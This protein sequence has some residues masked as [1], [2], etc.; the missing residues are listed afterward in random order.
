MAIKLKFDSQHNLIAP[1]FVLAHRNGKKIGAIKARNLNFSDNSNSAT[2]LSFVVDKFD[3]NVRYKYWDEVKDFRLVWCKEWD[4]WFEIRVQTDDENGTAKTI[5]GRTICEAEL[6]Q[7]YTGEMEINTDADIERDNYEPTIFFNES[8]PSSSLLHRILYKFPNYKILHVDDSIKNIQ[9][10]FSFS[11]NVSVYSALQTVSEEIDCIFVFDSGSDS[12]GKIIRGISVYDLESYCYDCNKRGVFTGTCPEC[13]STNIYEGYG[14]NTTIFI[15]TDNLADSITYSTDVDSVKNCFKLEAGDD[16]MTDTIINCNPNGT[17]YIWHISDDIKDDMDDELVEKINEYD[18]EYARYNSEYTTSFADI[19]DIA[20]DKSSARIPLDLKTNYN[21]LID[22]YKSAANE[23]DYTYTKLP[24]SVSGYPNLI[25]AYYNAIDFGLFLSNTMMPSSFIFAD[26]TAEIEAKKLTPTSLSP[27]SVQNIET[28]SNY[29]ASNSVL[30]MAKIIVDSRYQVKVLDSTLEDGS[31]DDTK[32]W[33]GNFKI[34]NYSDEEDSTTSAVITVEIN[35]NYDTFVRQKINKTLNSVDTGDATDIVSI[36]SLDINDGSFA[37]ELKKYCLNSLNS[38]HSAC[39]SCMDILI[40]QGIADNSNIYYSEMYAPY[41]Q[42][43]NIIEDEIALR[44]S[45]IAIIEGKYDSDGFIEKEGVKSAIEKVRRFV[46]NQLDFEYFLGSDLWYEFIAYRREEIYSNENYISDGLSNA[47]LLNNALEFIKVAQNEIYKSA[48]L[49]HSISATLKNLLVMKEF[50]KIVDYFEVGNWI[51]LKV[52]ENIYKLRLNNYQIDF[53]NM[54]NIQVEFSDV[55]K[56][57][58]GYSDIESTLAQAK[59]MSTTY[60]AVTRQAGQGEKSRKQLDNWV[61]DG[62]SLT[63]MKIINNAD[64]QNVVWD[65]HGMLCR[66]YSPITDEYDD[67]QTKIIN[68]GIYTTDDGWKTSKAGVGKFTYYDPKTK[69]YITAYGVIADTIVGNVNLSKEVGIYNSNNT[70]SLDENGFSMT[71]NNNKESSSGT[72][73]NIEKQIIDSDGNESTIP[74]I[75][76]DDEGNLV[77]HGSMRVE[78]SNGAEETTS[79]DTLFDNE[80]ISE[81]VL[82]RIHNE[83]GQ[84]SDDGNTN[85]SGYIYDVYR[86]LLQASKNLVDEYGRQVGQ[87]MRFDDSGL[88]IGAKYAD[89]SSSPFSTKITNAEL[90]F[91]N[92][93]NPLA[94]ISGE[95]L[96]IN[97]AIIKQAFVIGNFFFCPR[98]DG[99]MSISWQD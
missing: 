56:I 92:N 69:Q 6:S 51:R 55:K 16:L 45:E 98:N 11:N 9:R 95:Q 38:F 23:L 19:S 48:N 77:L 3:N 52:D 37:A 99:S 71:V 94:W 13:G 82:D 80:D 8:N 50:S 88:T 32:F 2:E 64:N 27:V 43:L 26:T 66:Q 54:D 4:I 31:S 20:I 17:A 79:L 90:Q 75:Y 96:Y 7:T 61:N 85:Q 29:T 14:K 28:C 84:W 40:E 34:T 70:I 35:G 49:Q 74:I 89:G 39:Q 93:T 78:S 65:D 62:L 12:N 5:N 24:D 86:S 76:V 60:G 36:F 67:C 21:N 59:N 73:F 68:N 22:K 15:S 46:Q 18:A 33:T 44:E 53:E 25:V 57:A 91:L 63:Q 72:I 81:K 10:S 97:N 1:T 83:Y 42:R 87:W 58:N 41:Y 30:S 47:E